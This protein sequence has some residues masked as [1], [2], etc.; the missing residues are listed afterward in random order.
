MQTPKIAP[1]DFDLGDVLEG[2]GDEPGQRQD[3]EEGGMVRHVH[4]RLVDGRE[5]L[6][7]YHLRCIAWWVFG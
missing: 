1:Q 7:A 3:V 4:H 5:V 6:E 2:P